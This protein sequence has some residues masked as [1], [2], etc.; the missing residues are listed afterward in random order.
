MP[1]EP[2]TVC[3][4]SGKNAT[5]S[6]FEEYVLRTAVEQRVHSPARIVMSEEPGAIWLAIW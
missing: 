5:D 3:L 2:E 4:P 6:N 1:D